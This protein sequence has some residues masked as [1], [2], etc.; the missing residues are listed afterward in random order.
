MSC[1]RRV[2]AAASAAAAFFFCCVGVPQGLAWADED[3]HTLL[4]SGRDIWR[5][6]AFAYGGF[7]FAPGGLEDDGFLIKF[8]FPEGS[9]D[10][11]R[12]IS[13]TNA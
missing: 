12:R 10:T 13:E 7:I 3:A 11:T 8:S 9:T 1:W 2:C 4:F 5:N 6:G